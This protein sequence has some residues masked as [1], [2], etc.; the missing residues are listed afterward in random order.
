MQLTFRIQV[1]P[2]KKKKSSIPFLEN[3]YFLVA[4]IIAGAFVA[5]F[6]VSHNIPDTNLRD[7]VPAFF[8]SQPGLPEDETIGGYIQSQTADLDGD[9]NLE[10]IVISFS[11]T[12]EYGLSKVHF[13]I[14]KKDGRMWQ[15]IF[16]KELEGLTLR[17]DAGSLSEYGKNY[18]SFQLKDVTGDGKPDVFLKM[19]A[20]GSGR[21]FGVFIFD[22]PSKTRVREIFGKGPIAHGQ[23]GIEGERIWLMEPLYQPDDPNCCPSSWKKTWWE[24]EGGFFVVVKTLI[25]NDYDT[26]LQISYTAIKATN[27]PKPTLQSISEDELILSSAR[28]YVKLHSTP[29]TKFSVRIT[30]KVGKYALVQVIPEDNIEGA[31]VIVEKV[32]NRWIAQDMGTAFPEWEARVP[33]LFR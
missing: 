29:E 5:G 25:R 26:L 12:D 23:A 30:K 24:Y 8:Q 27:T 17:D 9:K 19:R 28:D 15:K 2:Q 16:E 32:G 1:M 13:S 7:I 18:H 14:F 11:H 20:E 6:I 3:T 31:A 21:F 10:L 33:E 4:L 22:M